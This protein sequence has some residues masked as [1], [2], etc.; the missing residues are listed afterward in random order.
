M[1]SQIWR[2]YLNLW[3]CGLGISS[4]VEQ[5]EEVLMRLAVIKMEVNG[6]DERR[7]SGESSVPMIQVPAGHIKEVIYCSS[8]TNSLKTPCSLP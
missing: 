5:R 3:S 2:G 6:G 8:K 7:L 4:N 1:C